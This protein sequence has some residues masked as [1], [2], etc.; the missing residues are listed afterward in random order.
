MKPHKTTTILV[1]W[2]CLLFP[3]HAQESLAV[4]KPKAPFIVRPYQAPKVPPVQLKNSDRLHNLVR[5]GKLYLTVQDAIALAI[6]NNLDLQVDRYGPIAAEWQVERAQAGGPLRGV[7]SGNSLGNQNTSGQGVEGSQAAAGLGGGGNGGGGGGGGAAV[8]SQIGPITPNLDP[9]LQNS[10]GF[11]HSTVPQPNTTQSQTAALVDTKHIYD[12]AVTQGLLTGGVAQVSANEEYLKQNAPTD[13]LNPSVAPSVQIFVRHNFLQGFG[14]DVNSRFIRVAQKNMGAAQETFRSQ[15]LNLVASV[16]NLYWDLASDVEDLKA[17]QRTLDVAQKFYNDTKRQI[18]LSALAK[19]EIYRAQG[20][21]TTR[22]QELAISETTIRQ[23]ENLLKNA[24]S[25]NGLEDPLVDAAEVV[26]LDHIQVPEQDDLPALRELVARALAKRPD[27]A[28]A[29]IS[30]EN[31]EI[32]ALGTAS[33]LLPTLQGIGSITDTGLSGASNPQPGGAPADPYYVG[34]LG[35]ALGQVF[36]HNFPNWRTA[37][38][39]DGTVHNRVAQ[40]DYGVEQLQLRQNE[41]VTRR[42]MN[43]LVVDISNQVI[44]L[45]QAR[46]RYSTAVD[47]RV[48]QE[49]LLE[50]EQRKFSLGVSTINEVV[51]VQRALATARAAE[52]ASLATYSRARVSLDQVVG[53]TLEKN[54]VSIEEALDGRVAR[55]SKLP[56]LVATPKR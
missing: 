54:N 44:A 42:S 9:V 2:S 27:V 7:T 8:V 35:N 12:D 6:E 32:S 3:S 53:E 51:V 24:L 46:A 41:L 48:L 26:P 20:E 34:G 4:E 43:Q 52:V 40:G 5:A 13:V 15:L 23:Q 22:K 30:Q 49:Q 45:R 19:V 11:F 38:F 10:I 47:T 16:L 31:A 18:E 21:L 17:R 29:K 55:D 1:T 28:L 39:F 33:G 37:V 14:A 36:R 50:K 56:D 25:R